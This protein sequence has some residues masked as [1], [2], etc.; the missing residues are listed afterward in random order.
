MIAKE[1][2]VT[3]KVFLVGAG[4]GDPGLITIKGQALLEK[5]DVV[6]Y[7]YLANKKFLGFAPEGAEFIYVGKKGG[8][9]HAH[10]QA[11]INQMLL[12]HALAGK[13]VVRLKGGDPFIFGRGGEE[14]EEIVKMGIPFEVVPG[15][16]AASAA[17]TYAGIPI[18]H[19]KYTAT[20]AFITGHE[21]PTKKESNVDWEKLATGVGTLVFYMGIKN[22]SNITEKLINHGRDPQTPTAVIRWAST[23]EHRTVT[24]TLATISDIVKKEKIV[25]PAVIVVGEVVNLRNIMN[26][27][28]KKPLLGK[29]ILVTRTRS[30]ASELVARLEELGADC[31]EFA[32]IALEPPKSWEIFDQAIEVINQYDWLLFTSINAIQ[33]FFSRLFELGMDARVLNSL[34]IGVVGSA[35]EQELMKYGLKADLLPKGEF[36]G[37]S[38][39]K[40]LVK[41]GVQG[42]KIFLP[43]AAKANE[44]LP[45]ILTEAGAEVSIAPVYRNIRPQGREEELRKEFIENNINMITF[46]SSSTFTNF[47][48]M[49]NPEN[50]EELNQLLQGVHTASIGP[51]TSETIRE[52]G[53]SIDVQPEKYTIKALVE[54]IVAFYAP[55]KDSND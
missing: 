26:W 49:L 17:A 38:L 21:D 52:K 18:T 25:P 9:V 33:F 2:N 32:T 43:R 13:K 50:D 11:E 6:I 47:I 28:E 8:G 36:T 35:T 31:F 7:D 41:Q 16:T 30:Q 22:I 42:K 55:E 37:K 46:T 12:D 23:P 44:A 27:F 19:R 3:G 39:A 24:G 54:S 20:V 29:K 40:T 51:I 10:T 1:K 15:V 34:K 14:I 45:R 4:P 5:A 48:Y 53:L